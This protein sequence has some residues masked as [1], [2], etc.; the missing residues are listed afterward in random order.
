LDFVEATLEWKSL[1]NIILVERKVYRN[2]QEQIFKALYMT[3]LKDIS[4]EEAGQYIRNHWAIENQLYWHLDI[5]FKEDDSKIRQE[6]A[7][8]NLQVIRKWAL[9]LLKKNPEK[10]S[11][12][13][14]RKKAGRNNQYLKKLFK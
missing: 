5:T 1:N 6:N 11:L 2:N 10:I 8:I 9:H 3:G 13:R 7:I 12:K 4:P 14:K